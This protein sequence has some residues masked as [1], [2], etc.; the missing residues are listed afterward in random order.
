MLNTNQVQHTHHRQTEQDQNCF[1]FLDPTQPCFSPSVPASLPLQNAEALSFEQI[2]YL[3]GACVE[4]GDRVVLPNEAFSE[5]FGGRH[6]IVVGQPTQIQ[7]NSVAPLA[8]PP[9][10]LLIV[11]P[12]YN[13]EFNDGFGCRNIEVDRQQYHDRSYSSSTI[14]ERIRRKYRILMEKRRTEML[15]RVSR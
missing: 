11:Q 13:I 10:C 4:I 2:Q 6:H 14:M 8:A 7:M 5:V 12:R 9:S 3:S 1:S 15:A